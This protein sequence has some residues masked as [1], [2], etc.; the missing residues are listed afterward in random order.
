MKI[1]WCANSPLDKSGYGTQ[2]ALFAPRMRDLGHDITLFANHG[3]SGTSIRWEGMTVLPG[4]FDG[5]G[6][7]ILAGHAANVRPDLVIILADAWP[8]KPQVLKGLGC[9]VAIWM[10]VDCGRVPGDRDGAPA[11]GAADA[12]MLRESG[13]T[14]VAMSRYGEKM[15]R[16]A[17]FSPLY[18]PHGADLSV[19]RPAADRDALR[20]TWGVTGRFVIGANAAN[21][22]AFRKGW[23]EQ[24][25][26]F[27]R[28]R[29][30][31]PE[32]LLLA[33]TLPQMAGNQLD[34]IA[35]ARRLG[36]DAGAVMFTDQYRYVTGALTPANMA[37]WYGVLDAYSGCAYGEGFGIPLLEAQACGVPVVT[38]AWSA[39][40]ELKG[41]GWTVGGEP[42]WNP[43]HEA[44]W[45][46]PSVQQIVKAYEKAHKMASSKR[47]AA[48]EFA[49]GYDADRIVKGHWAPLLDQFAARAGV[50]A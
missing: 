19:F 2:T 7:D 16:A 31:H 41:P 26:A 8:L 29:M 40:T 6:N 44:W 34:L 28:F 9:P 4:A 20:E 35:L 37:D 15:L 30:R 43:V 48:R 49:G 42:V 18:V 47:E 3:I 1:L 13:A 23:P 11:V 21:K 24:L 5:Y 12:R 38:T 17:G 27:A 32:A 46:K 14:P 22:D 50:A 25:L 10:P 39:M 36:L 33:H 45:L